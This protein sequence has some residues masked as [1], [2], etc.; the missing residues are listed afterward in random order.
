MALPAN[1]P[2]GVCICR[3]P[4]VLG[5]PYSGTGY[6]PP[7]CAIPDVCAY[8]STVCYLGTC[9]FCNYV[10]ASGGNP[11]TCDT[12][13]CDCTQPANPTIYASA[14]FF[15]CLGSD[16]LGLTGPSTICNDPGV[17]PGCDTS[18]V[19][20]TAT[21]GT[22][23]GPDPLGFNGPST[24]CNDP[25]TCPGCDTAGIC[26]GCNNF[27]NDCSGCSPGYTNP[28]CSQTSPPTCTADCNTLGSS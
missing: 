12:P 18:A 15:T 23:T 8:N 20:A 28:P 10:A 9:T 11:A 27:N 19:Y 3:Q 2:S 5:Q 22:C 26:S 6:G 7:L 4:S 21:L 14:T 1:G 16:P 25:G 17:C 24:I 13:T